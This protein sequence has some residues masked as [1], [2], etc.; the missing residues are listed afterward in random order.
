MHT[1]LVSEDVGSGCQRALVRGYGNVLALDDQS[2]V[3]RGPIVIPR[4]FGLIRLAVAGVILFAIWTQFQGARDDPYKSSVMFWSEFTYQSN[5][6]VAIV[7]V[8]G[9]LFLV[10][11][12]Q[13]RHWWDLV[14]G[15]MVTYTAT[16]FVVYRFLV[17]GT[18]TSPDGISYYEQWASDVLHIW[19]PLFVLID[20]I[21]DP[22]DATI[23]WRQAAIWPLYPIG[24]CVYSLIRGP[25]V[26]WY[27]YD[28]L[29]PAEAGGWAGVALYVVAITAG[30]LAFS[31]AVAAIGNLRRR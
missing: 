12:I 11:D 27:P 30:F 24:F 8:I 31:A 2:R 22:P 29:D 1:Q 16:T 9:G 13:A 18:R 23:T 17:E 28:F 6:L 4:L 21:L 5:L 15:A 20:W 7:L 10:A 14:R 25:I 19:V 26:D 3:R